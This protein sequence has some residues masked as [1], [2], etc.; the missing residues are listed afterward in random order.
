MGLYYNTSRINCVQSNYKNGE[1]P[2]T[3]EIFFK[4]EGI[5][6]VDRESAGKSRKPGSSADAYEAPIGISKKTVV[7]LAII[8]LIAILCFTYVTQLKKARSGGSA[9]N[10]EVTVSATS[11]TAEAAGAAATE[12][13]AAEAPA[14]KKPAAEEPAAEESEE[15]PAEEA[16]QN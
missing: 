16:E 3:A 13:P 8:V 4:K 11:S 7:Y 10:E 5:I 14:A 9:A 6:M 2:G 12:E 1:L 15:E